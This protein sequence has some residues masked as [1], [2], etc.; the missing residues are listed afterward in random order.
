MPELAIGHAPGRAELDAFEAT[1]RRDARELVVGALIAD[2]AGRIFVQR[3]SEQRALFPGCW[4]L[5]GGHL[6]PDETIVEALEREIFEETGW[7]LETIGLVVYTLDWEA[8]GHEKREVDLLV[9]VAGDLSNPQLEREKV[10]EG[11]WL[12][13]GEVGLLL[14]HRRPRRH[15][16]LRG[17][18]A[19]LRAARRR[20]AGPTAGFTM[21]ESAEY[22]VFLKQVSLGPTYASLC[23]ARRDPGGLVKVYAIRCKLGKPRSGVAPEGNR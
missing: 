13:P 4:D 9:T 5:V 15:L 6:E 22:T 11:R 2:D 19:G 21:I 18:G 14:E 12:R 23:S 1:A 7:T 8:N 3:R 10:T 20:L 16:R 17:G